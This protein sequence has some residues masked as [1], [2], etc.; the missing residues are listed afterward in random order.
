MGNKV[1]W[2]VIG[3]VALLFGMAAFPSI[4]GILFST[5][6][7]GFIPLTKFGVTFLPYALVFFIGYA[8]YRA[9]KGN[10]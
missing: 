8:V 9:V 10:G 1:Y 2:V 5:D 6:T 3:I 4:S 7:T